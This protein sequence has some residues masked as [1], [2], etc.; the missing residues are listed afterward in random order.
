MSRDDRRLLSDKVRSWNINNSRTW[1]YGV[2]II[3]Y[4]GG[5]YINGIRAVHPNR[6][7]DGLIMLLRRHTLRVSTSHA[8]GPYMTRT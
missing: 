1:Y 4:L 3:L 8:L 5:C 7:W 6:T 2:S